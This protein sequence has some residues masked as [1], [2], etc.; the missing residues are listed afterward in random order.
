MRQ[1]LSSS[2]HVRQKAPSSPLQI[3]CLLHPLPQVRF[4]HLTEAKSADLKLG[5]VEPP[6]W[7]VRDD[8][9]QQH[10]CADLTWPRVGS[11]CW[12]FA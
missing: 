6:L 1:P 4:S 9:E 3:E 12:D 5:H 2:T 8:W 10:C 11:E 7:A